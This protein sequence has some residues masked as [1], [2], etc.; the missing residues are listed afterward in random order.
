LTNSTAGS[1]LDLMNAFF[2]ISAVC[3][4]GVA[5]SMTVDINSLGG[6]GIGN[7]F[8]YTSSSGFGSSLGG[9]PS[10]S[11]ISGLSSSGFG[12]QG[13]Y[14]GGG[15]SFMGGG[16]SYLGGG[17]SFM[18]GGSPFGVFMLLSY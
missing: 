1:N 18:G 10:F 7:D 5:H 9:N 14:F 15:G 11:G 13:D 6:S 8:P 12:G 17:G 3:L 16:G 4:V 2:F